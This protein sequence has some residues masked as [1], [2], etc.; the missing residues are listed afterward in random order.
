M[1]RVLPVLT[2]VV[3]TT[4]SFGGCA[5]MPPEDDGSGVALRV[6]RSSYSPRDPA[7]LTLVNGTA[8]DVGYNLSSRRWTVA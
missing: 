2:A 1:R 5:P 8:A 7:V 4:T 3:F 6:D